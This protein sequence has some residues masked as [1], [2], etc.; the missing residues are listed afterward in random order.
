MP[1]I[2]HEDR[3]RLKPVLDTVFMAGLKNVGELNY[4]ISSICQLFEHEMGE[5][6]NT[7]NSIVGALECVKAEWYRRKASPYEDQKKL[8]NG[9]IY[10]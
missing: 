6:Y 1:Y 10:S 7:H 8:E 2:K 5:S 3:E 4:V 9:D